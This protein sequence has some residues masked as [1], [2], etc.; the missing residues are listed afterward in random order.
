ML[1]KLCTIN[2]Q[3]LKLSTAYPC[4]RVEK[5]PKRYVYSMLTCIVHSSHTH[6]PSQDIEGNN[7]TGPP[8]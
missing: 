6:L 7:Q 1:Q 8:N 5:K 4:T 3:P 2:I